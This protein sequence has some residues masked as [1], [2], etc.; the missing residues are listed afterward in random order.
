MNALSILRAVFLSF[1]DTNT[2][3]ME[4]IDFCLTDAEARDWL[5][6]IAEGGVNFSYHRLSDGSVVPCLR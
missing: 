3:E 5:K 2:E 1:F 4:K 6:Q